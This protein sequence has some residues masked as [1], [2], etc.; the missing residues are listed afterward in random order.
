MCHLIINKNL[1]P[2]CKTTSNTHLFEEKKKRERETTRIV[3]DLTNLQFLLLSRL[4]TF[5]VS[6]FRSKT[7]EHGNGLRERVVLVDSQKERETWGQILI[8]FTRQKVIAISRVRDG[9]RG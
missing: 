6:S 5:V 3:L 4:E 9:R 2:P 7:I 8:G 1:D